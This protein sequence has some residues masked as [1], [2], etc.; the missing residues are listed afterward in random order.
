M[1]ALLIE[2]VTLIKQRQITVA[3]R[4]RGGATTTLALPRPLTAPQLRATDPAVREQIDTLL[5]AYTDAQVAHILN[6][7]GATTG[8]GTTFDP[9]SIRWVRCSARLKSLK[10]RLIEAGMLTRKQVCA[11]LGVGRN[12]LRR[13]RAEGRVQ[14]RI[15]NDK[16]ECLYWLPESA[17]PRATPLNEPLVTSV[18]GGAV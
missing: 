9:D 12:T 3:V 15:C 6:E 16:G 14:A 18:A 7:R 13:W 17:A 10:E 5:D 8:A 1:L 2:D 4:F 11:Q